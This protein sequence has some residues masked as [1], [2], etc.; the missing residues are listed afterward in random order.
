MNKIILLL[1]AIFGVH[2]SALAQHFDKAK[3]DRYLDTLGAHNKFMGSVAV[4]QNGAIIYQKSIGFANIAKGLPANDSSKYRIGSVS[5][6][7]TAVLTFKAIAQGKLSLDETIEQYV[8]QIKNADKITIGN[9][10]CHRSGIHNFTADTSYLGWHTEPHSEEQMTD[11]IAKGGSDFE[12]GTKSDYSNSNY[13]LLTFIL[14]KVFQQPYAELLSK[15][16]TTPLGLKN[17]YLGGKINAEHNE[18]ASYLYFGSWE[19]QPET[20][21]SIPLGAGGIVSTPADLLK[22]SNALFTGKLIS[23]EY[24]AQMKKAHG[25]FGM[26][27]IQAPFYGMTTYGHTGGIDGFATDYCHVDSNDIA[28]ALMANGL[29]YSMNDISLAV[30]SA[31]Y[32][33]DY[34]IPSFQVVQVSAEI[35]NQ[36]TGVY[37]TTQIPMKITVSK[38]HET[39]MAQATGQSSFPLTPVSE[40]TFSFDQAGIVIQFDAEKHTLELRQGGSTLLFTKE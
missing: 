8:P 27:L 6:T 25:D 38:D 18:C 12:P 22:F 13:V 9:L 11:I 40:N 10:L 33:I 17:T 23:L 14:E 19:L 3:L 26:G 37:S 21:I 30:L 2:E 36:Y 1:L 16:I 32:G 24:L 29:N 31:A 20:D 7:F 15:Y 5:K 34:S 4:S 28:F 35:L 39:L